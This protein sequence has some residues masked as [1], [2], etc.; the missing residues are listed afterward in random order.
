[1]N[2]APRQSIQAKAQ[3]LVDTRR[4]NSFSDACAMLGARRRKRAVVKPV[5]AVVRAWWAE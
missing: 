2:N 1:V 4:A 3:R 5:V